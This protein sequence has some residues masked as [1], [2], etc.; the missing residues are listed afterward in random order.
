MPLSQLLLY[1][2]DQLIPLGLDLIPF[3]EEI[4]ALSIAGRLEL[5]LQ[6]TSQHPIPTAFTNLSVKLLDLPLQSVLQII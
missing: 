5:L 6:R 2:G 1:A 4:P 3:I